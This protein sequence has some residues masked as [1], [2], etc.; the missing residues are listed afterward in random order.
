MSHETNTDET[1]GPK[2]TSWDLED[3]LKRGGID[4]F[5]ALIE[6]PATAKHL[7][8]RLDWPIAKVNYILNS[9]RAKDLV[10]IDSQPVSDGAAEYWFRAKVPTFSVI[11]GN[12]DTMLTRLRTVVEIINKVSTGLMRS[13]REG[14][15][16][17]FTASTNLITP[18]KML[19]FRE[20]LGELIDE[21]DSP[22]PVSDQSFQCTM[23]VALYPDNPL[24]EETLHEE[25][26]ANR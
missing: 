20:R 16:V 7:A 4:A 23:A 14:G 11:V 24:S 9:L 25:G 17:T 6:A 8:L 19:E 5:M 10:G 2:I 3:L 12:D 13:I 18:D 1:M 21:Y 22:A 26:R 15:P